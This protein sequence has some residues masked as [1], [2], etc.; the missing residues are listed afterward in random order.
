MIGQ[1][2]GFM[3]NKVCSEILQNEDIIR[4]LVIEDDHFLNA[5]P[6]SDKQEYIDN[7]IKLMRNYIYPYKRIFDTTVE[8]KTIISTEFSNF[9]KLGKN[10]RNGLVT[11]YILVPVDLENTTYGIRYDFIG[12]ELENIFNNTNIGEFS[13]NS[14]GDID[15]GDRY[16]GHYISF[17]ITEFHIP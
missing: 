7:P 14:R 11:F 4:A 13:F 9:E 3:R 16:I 10:Y 17:Q 6:K 15:V 8:K 5:T 2:F 12:D 1:N